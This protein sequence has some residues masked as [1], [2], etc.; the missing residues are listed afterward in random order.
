[1]KSLS[2]SEFA[3]ALYSFATELAK[4]YRSITGNGVRETLA[5]IQKLIPLTVHEVPTGT[6]TL[7]W[8][9]PKEWNIRDA[10]V[11][12]PEGKKILDFK[13]NYLHV[14]GYSIPIDQTVSLKELDQ[15][16]YS[17][18]EQPDAIPYVTSYYE[19]RWG[20]CIAHRERALLKPGQYR[21]VIDSELKDG[22]LTYGEYIVPGKT[23]KEIL[24]STY[25]CHPNMGNDNISGMTITTFLAQWLGEKP[26]HYTYRVVFVPE[27]IGSIV[28]MS[29]HLHEM[30]E[31]CVAGF[32]ITCVGDEGRFSFL[33]SRAGDT[34]ADRIALRTLKNE[35]PDFIHYSFLD[36]GS[37]ERQYCSPAADLPIVSIMRSKY[38]TY[39]EYHT[40]LDDLDFVTPTGLSG[41]YDVLKKC[42]ETL[43][44]NKVYRATTIG[45]PQLSKRGLYSTLSVRGSANDAKHMMDFLAY[46]DGTRDLAALAEII[47]A[48]A[49]DIT[50][51]ADKLLAAGLIVVV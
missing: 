38:G 30:R 44:N 1:M 49:T 26:R 24:L 29:K 2:P 17:L 43:E 35:H 31:R 47:R 27:T 19:E 34:L 36:R 40:S 15:H 3:R 23:E 22:S 8:N 9:V 42:L 50:L 16:L 4:T 7:D 12:D 21:V 32:N 39:P 13:T 20:F 25:T 48:S 45:E 46:A 28:Y 33:P 41:S 10:Y 11:I 6:Q 5:L 18:P 51:L 37:D 14:L